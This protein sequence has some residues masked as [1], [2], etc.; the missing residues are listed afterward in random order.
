M[1]H[2]I[3]V[4]AIIVRNLLVVTISAGV[5]Q[6][7]LIPILSRIQNIVTLSTKLHGTHGDGLVSNVAANV[8]NSAELETDATAKAKNTT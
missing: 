3:S 1:E 4:H 2:L 6:N 5:E 8:E 7:L